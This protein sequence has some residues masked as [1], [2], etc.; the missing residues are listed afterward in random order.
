MILC[1]SFVLGLYH[2]VPIYFTDDIFSGLVT[3][4][5]ATSAAV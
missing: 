4:Y 5:T 3:N 1:D 2:I